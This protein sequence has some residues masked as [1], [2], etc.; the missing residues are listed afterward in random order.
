MDALA[1]KATPAAM[2]HRF[3][4]LLLNVMNYLLSKPRVV[5]LIAAAGL[6]HRIGKGTTYWGCWRG[7]KPSLLAAV[8]ESVF[9]RG[10]ILG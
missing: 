1:R 5:A 4:P 10:R 9:W 3:I 2:R 8:L 6:I 7:P